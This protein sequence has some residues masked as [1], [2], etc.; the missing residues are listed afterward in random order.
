MEVSFSVHAKS[1]S[2]TLTEVK[3]RN[4][5]IYID[6]PPNLGGQDKGA[7]PVEYLLATLAGCIN[8]VGS[9][10]AKEMGINFENFEIEIKGVLDPS[11]FQGKQTNERAGFKKIDVN[12]KVKTNA[13]KQLVEKWLETVKNRC[14]VSDNLVNPTPVSFNLN[15]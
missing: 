10:V 6:E 1:L 13:E 15:V 4:F 12:I 5:T 3:A 9:L 11:K 2:K 7:T 14:P 8:V